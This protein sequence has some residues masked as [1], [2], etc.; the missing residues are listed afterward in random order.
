[1]KW[2]EHQSGFFL[3]YPPHYGDYRFVD[4][5]WN[6]HVIIGNIFQNPELLTV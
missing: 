1:V 2:N 5:N 6:A 3:D 4:G